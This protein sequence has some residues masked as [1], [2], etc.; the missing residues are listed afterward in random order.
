MVNLRVVRLSVKSSTTIEILFT[1]NLDTNLGVE[2]ISIVGASGGISNPTIISVV[3]SE[4]VLT[5]SIRPLIPRA[6]YKITLFSTSTKPFK[7]SKGE[8]L[9]EDGSNNV[10]FFVGQ[11]EDNIVRDNIIDDLPDIYD[12]E[13]GKLVFDSIDAGS[14]QILNGVHAAGEV[15]SA[16]YVSIEVQDV[17]MTRGSGPYD[18]FPNEGVYQLLRVGS[19]PTSA[20]EQNRIEFEEFPS[21]PISLQQILVESETVSNTS[22]DSNNFSGLT[23]TLSKKPVIKILS[24]ELI[25]D[26]VTYQYDITQYKYG[27]K[28]SKYDSNNSYL[29]VDIENDQIRLSTSSI[30]PNF[31]LPQGSDTILVSYY[32]KKEGRDVDPDSIEVFTT[33]NVV[34]ESV[35]A[36]AT[37]FFLSNAPV[38]DSNGNIPTLNGVV[39]LDPATNFNPT[40]KHPAFTAEIAFSNSSFPNQTGEYSIN[41]STGQ[42]F[43]FGVD[44]SGVDGTTSIPP[45]A[46]YTYKKEYQANLDYIFFSDLDEIASVPSRELRGNSAIITFNYED[47]FANGSDFN[48]SSHVEII[49]ERVENRLI[50]DIGLKTINYPVNEVF[51]IY[52]ETTGELYTPIRIN[53]NEVYFSASQPPRTLNVLREAVTYESVI[54]SQLVITATSSETLFDIFTIELTDSDIMSSIGGFLGANFNTSLIFSEQDLFVNE[55]YYSPDKTISENLQRLLNVGDYIVDYESGIVYLAVVAGQSTDIGDATYKRNNIQTR[56]RHI[57]RVDDIY[58]SSSVSLPN[59]EIFEV[60][61]ISDD[62]VNV[63]SLNHAGEI[64]VS[65][66][67]ITVNNNTIITSSD[68]F[69]LYK[70]F[71]VTDLQT[72]SNPINFATN[73]TFSFKT[74][75]LNSSGVLISDSGIV[76]TNGEREYVEA[77]RIDDLYSQGLVELTSATS[78][79][80]G[81]LNYFNQGSDGYVDV[82]NNRIY[83]P[84]GT[85]IIGQ[86]VNITYHARLRNNAAVLV[87]YSVGDVFIDYTYSKDELLVSYEYGDNI[88][89][90]SI[91]SSLYEGETYYVS[92][93]YGALR[94]ALR[95]NFGVLTSLPELSVIPDNL[96]RE[97]Y[98]NAVS[99]S[100]QSFMKGP[101]IPSIEALVEAFTQITPN[102]TESVFQEWIL[103]RDYFN[104]LPIELTSNPGYANGKFG[105][106]LLL[107]QDSQTAIFPAS[108]NMKFSEGTWEAFIIPNWSGI[109]NDATLTFDLFMDNNEI[110]VNKI[111]IGS[112]AINPTS[113]PFDLDNNNPSVLG[114]PSNLH[115]HGV[116]GYF[117]WFDTGFNC[118]RLRTRAPIDEERLFSGIISTSGEFYNVK[119][120]TTASGYD[121]YDGYEIDEIN[122]RLWST[123]ESVKFSFIID[124]YDMMNMSFDAYDAYDSFGTIAGFD[125]IDL[126]SDN[127]HYFFDTGVET[128]KCRMSL[129]KDGSGFIK[130]RIYDNNRR[131]K[132]L[133]HNINNWLPG[134]THHLAVSWKM[135]TIE[136]RDELHL[137]VDGDEVPNSYRFKGYLDVPA[138]VNKNTYRFKNPITVPNGSK[139]LDEAKEIL[140]ISATSPTIGG[141]D[142]QTTQGSS[143]VVSLSSNFSGNGVSI[144]N[145]FEIL[146]DTTDGLSTQSFPFA[147][148]KT[149]GQNFL[150]IEVGDSLGLPGS[151]VLWTANATLENIRYTINPLELQTV[152][153]VEIEKIRIFVEDSYGTEIE[154]NSPNT[155]TPDYSLNKDGY[156]DFVNIY[157]GVSTGSPISIKT[158]GL[159]LGRCSQFVYV[160]PDLKTNLLNTIMP[161]P[162]AISKINIVNM[163]IKRTMIEPGSFALIATLVGGHL[164]TILTSSLDFCQPSNTDTGRSLT[165]T[166]SG[167][168][169]DW[170]G[171]NQVVIVGTTYDGTNVEIITFSGPGKQSTTKFFTSLTDINVSF[172]PIDSSLSAGAIEIRETFPINWP[173][174]SGLYAD[175]HLSSIEQV[176]SDGYVTSGSPNLTD[177]Y[178]RFG[179]EDINKIINIISAKDA[180]GVTTSAISNT[181]TI[182]DVPLDP[183]GTAKDSNSVVLDSTFPDGYNTISWRMLNTSYGNSG[184]AN[185]LITLETARTGGQPFLLRS[186]W[187]EVDFP[188]YLII[189]WNEIPN[190]IYIG[191]DIFGENQANA[192]ID[193][194]RILDEMSLDTHTGEI[195][196]SS[197]RS[198]STDAIAVREFETTNQT[199]AL[200]HFNEDIENSANFI[201]SFSGNYKQSEN[202]VNTNFGQSAIFNMKKS[203]QIDNNAVFKNNEGTVEFWVSPILDTY[204]DPSK[205]YYIDLSSEISSTAQVITSLSIRLPK[206]ARAVTSIT[207]PGDT[208]NYF[209]GGS[210]AND[211]I[212]VRL[213]QQLPVDILEVN[214]T[215]VPIATQGDRFSIFKN[216]IGNLVF[217]VTASGVDYQISTP[218]Y[219]KKNTWHRVFAG[220]DLN[221]SDG[222]DRLIFIVDGTEGGIV[223]YGTG[224][225]YGTGITYGMKTVWGSADVG[226]TISR[227]ILADINLLDTFNIINIGADFTEQYSALARMDNIRFSSALRPITYLGAT[228]TDI[229]VGLGPG[230]LIGKDLLYTSNI[231]AALPVID[232]A[233]TGLLLDFN[234]EQNEVEYLIQIRDATTGIFDFFVEVIDTF[235]LVDT[236]LAHQLIEDLINRIKPSHTRAFVSF[237]K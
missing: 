55:L 157:N 156:M 108:S 115:S 39:W 181:Y 172:S 37:S 119:I 86:N 24:I 220:W 194:M 192:V 191:S 200:F 175:I 232:D 23:I 11:Q 117:I 217:S 136:Q 125:G 8:V 132:V 36:V 34:R 78:I 43:V 94:N 46:N 15:R 201:T 96:D 212:N 215:Y 176:G 45:V 208:T 60:G 82:T 67:V 88:L 211:G 160:W 27:I 168:N 203:L 35:S 155:L 150:E 25:R 116:S 74:I 95:D 38:V 233:I 47:T 197:G 84:S 22:N 56:N 225:I 131:I 83:L 120:A 218:I 9:V 5:I 76:Q 159:T 145:R 170:F 163:I 100:L 3:P 187:Y 162:T 41:Y 33:I 59:I 164:V 143:Q 79:S 69:K 57:I 205:R 102:I 235:E 178:S 216:E 42:V 18:R 68:I 51:R 234:T 213:G 186:C 202:S 110:D 185:G 4:K 189:P 106:G 63:P 58:R 180:Y 40:K 236:D 92:Y 167:N 133:S 85:N 113:I 147:Y 112:T 148:V 32:Y 28:E 104:L 188:A 52:N 16:N 142:L 50:E 223:R 30:G 13:P 12:A 99:G 31:P 90:W 207:I 222:Q 128:N 49:N 184:F 75:S 101:T 135:G 44:G 146:D 193:E 87:D 77:G 62:V 19:F 114:V 1:H 105:N 214:I 161:A 158:Y 177:I 89:D 64:E 123:D 237:T 80:N 154:L 107:D 152:S 169:I 174:N 140:V 81:S 171:F 20:K 173:E 153:D 6:N 48:F 228:E 227:N 198:I 165:I 144:G 129:Y 196:P 121:G 226:T 98:R 224:L 71:Q 219:W 139:F 73:A 151:G 14:K 149:V 54:Q 206:R 195:L 210:L 72:T 230:K 111:Y 118:W 122:D 199:L 141:F 190:N 93:R 126:T 137:F 130:F 109:Q 7:G 26:N 127:L 134:E 10:I 182:I 229:V 204:N 103:G 53:G 209:I 21:D 17:A 183:S 231:N 29:A 221:N 61:S 70:I 138:G 166:V 91:S 65:G 66:T 124:D 179:E 2:N 97:T